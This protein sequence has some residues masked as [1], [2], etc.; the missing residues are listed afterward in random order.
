MKSITWVIAIAAFLAATSDSEGQTSDIEAVTPSNP[1]PPPGV[2]S[3]CNDCHGEDGISTI[4]NIP[5]LAGQRAAYLADEINAYQD[6]LRE[7]ASMHG[8]VKFLDGEEVTAIATYYSMLGAGAR[9]QSEGQAD[10]TPELDSALGP[11]AAEWVH[12]CNHCHDDAAFADPA[13]FP[14]LNGQRKEYLVEAMRSYKHR[15]RRESSMMH[16]MA[17]KLSPEVIDEIASY[18]ADR[19]SKVRVG[20]PPAE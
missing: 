11:V 12:K 15:V 17:Y 10:A 1:A 19:P 4:R 16:A 13:R 9:N 5:H 14:I 8:I 7:N 2:V 20:G 3:L 18:Y 6:G